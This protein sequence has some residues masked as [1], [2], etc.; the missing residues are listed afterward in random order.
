MV[1]KEKIKINI[2]QICLEMKK[3]DKES[4]EDFTK[5]NKLFFNNKTLVKLED[6]S[7]EAFYNILNE[8]MNDDFINKN[9]TISYIEKKIQQLI[10]KILKR[11]EKER[12]NDLDAEIS[13]FREIIKKDIK[14][15]TFI[16]PIINLKIVK[17]LTI[18][19]VTFVNFSE[20]HSSIKDHYFKIL[21]KS[22]SPKKVIDEVK[23]HYANMF[24]FLNRFSCAKV[25]L[26]GE[27]TKAI[28]LCF[29]LVERTLDVFR[30]YAPLDIYSSK[31]YIGIL[32][33]LVTTKTT[34]LVYNDS[35]SSSHHEARGFLLPFEIDAKF[36][37]V[38]EKNGLL[39]ISDILSRP[40]NDF[41]NSII[42]A[43]HWFGKAIKNVEDK[44]RFI[45]FFIALETL[46]IKDK[47]ES[48]INC[49]SERTAF[50]FEK[51]RDRRIDISRLMKDLYE[52]RSKIVHSGLDE[53]P[54]KDM[55]QMHLIT[56]Q[57]LLTL[58]NGENYSHRSDFFKYLD[59]LK[60][61]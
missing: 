17:P 7:L 6:T 22:K 11:D 32:G 54:P 50:L 41:E 51:E 33:D 9:F 61:S 31:A 44:D 60:Y 10:V 16:V 48:I 18:G 57:V 55:K 37:K 24:Q 8:F 12:L 20:E 36:I 56:Q 40:R 5:P 46:L 49:L 25:S 23:G 35:N 26:E 58:I 43:I 1:D 29:R 21:A 38:T 13:K 59:E 52:T 27:S 19:E 3:Q 14:K 34:I 30:L 53:V 2:E 15:W 45:Y 28:E 47:N 4:T 39:K 42:T